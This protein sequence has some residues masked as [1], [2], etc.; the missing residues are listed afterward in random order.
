MLNAISKIISKCKSA[1]K[2]TNIAQYEASR[3]LRPIGELKNIP[4][5]EWTEEEKLSGIALAKEMIKLKNVVQNEWPQQIKE[6]SS[7]LLQ[8]YGWH[9]RLD[10]AFGDLIPFMHKGD[11]EVDGY[12]MDGLNSSTTKIQEL[13]VS[14]FPDRAKMIDLAFIAHKRGEYELSV[15][16][17]LILSEGIFR[18]MSNTDIFGNN[19][20]AKAKKSEFIENLKKNKEIISL[21]P[22]TIEAVIEGEI[23]GLNFSKQDYL[24]FPNVLHRNLIIHGESVDYGT[25]VNSFKALS[26]FEFVVRFVYM[27]T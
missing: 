18:S 7:L 20:K 12:M 5:E 2:E 23:I 10:M 8:H 14:R 11:H 22:Y 19:P 25:K 24:K 13:A 3:T 27:I 17:F 6:A 26:Q 15:P 21:L 4:H 16:A 9:V 1:K